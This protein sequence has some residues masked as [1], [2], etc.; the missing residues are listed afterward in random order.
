M[1]QEVPLPLLQAVVEQEEEALRQGLQTLQA[2]ELLVEARLAP[3][4]VYTFKHALIQETA[5]Q[6]LL[7][8]TRQQVHQ[9]IAQVWTARFPTLVET[10][11][12][13]LAQHYTEAGLAEQA[14]GYWQH[15]GER[16][17]GR[18]AYVE[19]VAQLSRGLEVLHTLPDTPA[20]ARQELDLQLTLGWALKRSKGNGAP[21]TG[22]AY[23]RAQE[24]C[25]QVGDTPQLLRVLE[26]LGTFHQQRGEFQTARAL[27]EQYLTLA[28][29]HPDPAF[30]MV[31][32]A[33]LGACVYFLGELPVAEAHL[34]QGLALAAPQ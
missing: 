21:E 20:R 6:L 34:E 26:G 3:E 30:L 1:G 4:P 15:A 25:R 32:Y 16:S 33:D 2:A 14:V 23:T 9:R 11:P 24:L 27:L 31:A 8:R 19:A 7:K 28:Q 13:R 5:Y 22:Q 10:Q 29:D 12:E 17:I 18:S